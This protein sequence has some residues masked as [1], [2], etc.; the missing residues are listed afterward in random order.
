MDQGQVGKPKAPAVGEDVTDL[1]PAVGADVTALMSASRPEP[2]VRAFDSVTGKELT[3][4]PEQP[5]PKSLVRQQA[6]Q[7]GDMAKATGKT[8][9][10]NVS[11]LI[12]GTEGSKKLGASIASGEFFV[13]LAKSLV[14]LTPAHAQ[15]S[16]KMVDAAKQGNLG[17]AAQHAVGMLPMLGPWLSEQIELVKQGKGGT[18]AGNLTG[19]ALT[20]AKPSN[21][22]PPGTISKP[23]ASVLKSSSVKGA[24]EFL[25]ATT[26]PL[27]AE[28]RMV[29]PGLLERGLGKG[30]PTRQS[31][32]DQAVAQAGQPAEAGRQATFGAAGRAIQREEAATAAANR[33]A[34]ERAVPSRFAPKGSSPDAIF[35]GV[36]KEAQETG[37]AGTPAELR[38]KFDEALKQAASEADE[39]Y[40]LRGD[41]SPQALFTAV[42]DAGGIGADRAMSGEVARLW[43]SST[44]TVV[45]RGFTKSG[46]LKRSRTLATGGFGGVTNVLRKTGGKPL[47][48]IAEALR[49]DP[50]FAHI[51]GPQA[52][53]E[54]LDKAISGLG[55]KRGV[56][57]GIDAE[58]ALGLTGV[59]PGVKWWEGNYD[60]PPERTATKMVSRPIV[61]AQPIL[62]VFD[63]II[64]RATRVD[65]KGQTVPRLGMESRVTQ[66]KA[67]RDYVQG[68]GD[69]LTFEDAASLKRDFQELADQGKQYMADDPTKAKAWVARKAGTRV[70]AELLKVN[71]D[72]AKVWAEY[73][74]W[75]GV[76][77]VLQATVDRKA[78]QDSWGQKMKATIWGS[79]TG[80]GAFMHGGSVEA[81]ATA[82]ATYTLARALQSP[83]W[84][85]VSAQLKNSLA[86][87]IAAGEPS[88]VQFYLNRI[89][90]VSAA[91]QLLRIPAGA[92]M[93]VASH[94]A[95]ER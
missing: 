20:F 25:N 31:V 61:P 51:D 58:D 72:L 6:D 81:A 84:K 69:K 14:G 49:Q 4:G 86:D 5:A 12:P 34:V 28:S 48:T 21:V 63:S 24:S 35:D 38:V 13:D 82:A 36:L 62:D 93:P 40:R 66:A 52:L 1:M 70:R 74:F 39:M 7:L 68:Y 53:L 46:S 15:E 79:S 23:V 22:I 32:L 94:G 76:R 77:D 30:L 56:F 60:V 75:K 67:L 50:R 41:Y 89:K 65:A 64:R 85:L 71:P 91:P 17:Q 19:M 55:R 78:S 33:V 92:A 59:N 45:P 16:Q 83:T 54:E 18:A 2:V 95:G 8:Y 27:K 37:Y 3:P 10:D 44:G 9:W 88:R 73:G 47:D 57:S 90:A 80:A 26:K 42:R 11:P 87:A 43:E 29:V